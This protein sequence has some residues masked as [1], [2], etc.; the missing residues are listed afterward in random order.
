MSTSEIMSGRM[1]PMSIHIHVRGEGAEPF[2]TKTRQ[3]GKGVG[4]LPG[5]SWT[6]CRKR[7]TWPIRRSRASSSSRCRAWASPAR[8]RSRCLCRTAV[9][10]SLTCHAPFAAG[11]GRCGSVYPG[12]GGIPQKIRF[13]AIP[14]SGWLRGSSWGGNAAQLRGPRAPSPSHDPGL[15]RTTRERPRLD[16]VQPQCY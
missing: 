13:G 12:R 15:T 16:Q 5:G 8:V 3:N 7:R 11:D 4:S 1:E 9:E 2:S 10:S 14:R 6:A